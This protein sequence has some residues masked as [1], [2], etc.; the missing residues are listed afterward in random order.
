MPWADLRGQTLRFDD[1]LSGE[2]YSPR[3]GSEIVDNGMYV[4][5]EPWEFNFLSVA[6][7]GG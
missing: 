2:R 6:Q 3:D 4:R 7:A 5:L 1:L